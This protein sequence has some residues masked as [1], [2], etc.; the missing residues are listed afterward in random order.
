MEIQ[1]G[2]PLLFKVVPLSLNAAFLAEIFPRSIFV[3]THRDPL[4]VAQSTYVNRL[5]RYGNVDTWWSLKPREYEQLKLLKP[6]DQVA[7]QI[8]ICDYK[9][10][11]QVKRIST[12]RVISVEYPT[13]CDNPH[14]LV[15]KLQDVVPGLTRTSLPIPESFAARDVQTLTDIEFAAL[16]EAMRQANEVWLPQLQKNE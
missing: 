6:M 10:A 12:D 2:N 14:N 7:G 4:F 9:I 15:R 8:C 11:C 3:Y 5:K 16:N 13:L 1:G